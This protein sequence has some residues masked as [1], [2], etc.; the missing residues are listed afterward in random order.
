MD[1]LAGAPDALA[2]IRTLNAI[3]PPTAAFDAAFS[4]E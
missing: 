2:L 3:T 4:A 1:R